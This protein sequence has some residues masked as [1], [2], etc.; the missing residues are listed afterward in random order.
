MTK[1]CTGSACRPDTLDDELV[2]S[3]HVMSYQ[4][5]RS[6]LN[7][8]GPWLLAE[9]KAANTILP[10]AEMLSAL[11]ERGHS[12]SVIMG[13]THW[14]VCWS[15]SSPQPS[16]LEEQSTP[17]IQNT[18]PVYLTPQLRFIVMAGE[19]HIGPLPLFVFSPNMPDAPAANDSLMVDIMHATAA[20]LV[21]LRPPQRT[22]SIFGPAPLIQA[23]A[24]VWDGY[25]VYTRH[26]AP[27]NRMQLLVHSS[28][29]VDPHTAWLAPSAGTGNVRVATALDVSALARLSQ[30]P[31]PV[32]IFHPP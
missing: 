8:V 9:Q 30:L 25:S 18:T 26:T 12:G 31:S 10:Y 11:E 7:A 17:S 13:D 32:S 15:L 20:R 23:F 6:F 28:Q 27:L 19:S 22:S 5:A 4:T 29:R 24:N 16:R 1:L 2:P 21:Q 3:L 14:V